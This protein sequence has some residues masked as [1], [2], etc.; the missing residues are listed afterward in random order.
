[1]S[2][3][4]ECTKRVVG[5]LLGG[6]RLQAETKRVYALGKAI[7]D[8]YPILPYID[9]LGEEPRAKL[10]CD[11]CEKHGGNQTAPSITSGDG[12]DVAGG[13]AVLV[14]LEQT[15][16]NCYGVSALGDEI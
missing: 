2:Q 3:C 9:R 14:T 8:A 10:I 15:C 11:A 4:D 5:V 12:P 6:T 1:M 13:I 16:K 7:L